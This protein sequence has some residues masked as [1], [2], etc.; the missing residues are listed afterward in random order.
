MYEQIDG[1]SMGGSLGSALTNIIITE[2]KKV[3]VDKFM[4]KEVL[5]F[6]ARNIDNTLLI[7]KKKDINYVL[8]QFINFLKNLKFTL[9]HLKTVFHIFLILK[10]VQ[11]DL[12]FTINIP[13]LVNIFTLPPI[14]YGDGKLLGSVH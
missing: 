1:V 7:F 5:M 13:K 14:H 12:I 3:I 2:C 10:F 8:N 4:K 9:T 6:Y 11:M